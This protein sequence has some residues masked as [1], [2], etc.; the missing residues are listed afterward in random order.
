MDIL[1]STYLSSSKEVDKWSQH[2]DIYKYIGIREVLCWFPKGPLQGGSSSQK[3]PF[4]GDLVPQR[5]PSRGIWFP[6]GP[7]RGGSF[8]LLD[9]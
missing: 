2:V 1:S 9:F 8:G 7:L 6:K 5:S 4:E 3:V